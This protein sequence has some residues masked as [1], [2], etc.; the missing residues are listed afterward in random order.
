MTK[1]ELSA[2]P[3]E[4]F[5]VRLEPLTQAHSEPLARTAADSKI[6]RWLSIDLSTPEGFARWFSA[7][8]DAMTAGR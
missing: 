5:G 1:L 2:A 4:G 3:L 6:W 7:A 8:W